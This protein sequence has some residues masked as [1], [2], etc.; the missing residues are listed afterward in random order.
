MTTTA[1]RFTVSLMADA[2]TSEGVFE[3]V[4]V[5]TYPSKAAA[6]KAAKAQVRTNNERQAQIISALPTDDAFTKMD[7][8][9]ALVYVEYDF[10]DVPLSGLIV[11]SF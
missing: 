5:G 2:E 9:V 8:L 1:D 3:D 6:M 11:E 10:G 7:S 4:I